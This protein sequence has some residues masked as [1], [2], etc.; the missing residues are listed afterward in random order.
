MRSLF[1]AS[2]SGILSLLSAAGCAV[3]PAESAASD[4]AEASLTSSGSLGFD[5]ASPSANV[6]LGGHVEKQGPA[7]AGINAALEAMTKLGA[8]QNVLFQAGVYAL[9]GAALTALAGATAGPREI[10]Y[11]VMFRVDGSRPG[12]KQGL[13]FQ[14]KLES[15]E[16]LACAVVNA[17]KALSIYKETQAF[18]AVRGDQSLDA[19][20]RQ[21]LDKDAALVVGSLLASAS[22]SKL[23]TCTWSNNDDTDATALVS[24][25]EG[26]GIVRV[27]LAWAGG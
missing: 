5:G 11:D 3:S 7:S 12:S 15:T 6:T 21:T 18:E 22:P 24:V 16:T 20:E 13:G 23:V 27:L 17:N 10:A 1:I 9:D 19:A 4:G 25:D 26:T 2:F 14:E 8:N